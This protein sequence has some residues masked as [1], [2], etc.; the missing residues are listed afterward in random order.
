MYIPPFL[1]FLFKLSWIG[2]AT[3]LRMHLGVCNKGNTNVACARI[4]EKLQQKKN[5][6]YVTGYTRESHVKFLECL[7]YSN[8]S[9]RDQLLWRNWLARLTVNQEVGGS[10][11]PRSVSFFVLD[12]ALCNLP[13]MQ[14]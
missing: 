12:T 3:L 14:M 10:S 8:H 11:P 4:S 1:F 6:T 13:F 5:E 9:A 2:I 7:L